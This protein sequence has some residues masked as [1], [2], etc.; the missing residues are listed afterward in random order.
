MPEPIL[1][2]YRA[3]VGPFLIAR[4]G[5]ALEPFEAIQAKV[6]ALV[7]DARQRA[8]DLMRQ[9]QNAPHQTTINLNPWGGP[10]PGRSTTTSV[11]PYGALGL[12]GVATTGFSA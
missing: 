6:A 5:E 12:G 8:I 2:G 4:W 11:N 7:T 1:S 3:T 10:Q 9:Y